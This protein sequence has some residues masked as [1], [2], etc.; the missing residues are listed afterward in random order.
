MATK[1]FKA[2]M[3]NP[4]NNRYFLYGVA[5]EEAGETVES[6][7]IHIA[8]CRGDPNPI[9]INADLYKNGEE[10]E[11]EEYKAH[12]ILQKYNKNRGL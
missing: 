3:N 11:A 5:F 12:R 2:Y 9:F 6:K 1:Y 10:M 7:A 4:F 8:K